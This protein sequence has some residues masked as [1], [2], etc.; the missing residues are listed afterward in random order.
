MQNSSRVALVYCEKYQLEEVR[1]AVKTGLN[2]LGGAEQFS[3]PQENIL[4]KVNML[5]G[6]N[7]DKCVGPHPMVF[8]AVL[9]QS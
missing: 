8:Q 2:L 5:V 1:Q 3:Q 7:P 9:E 6:D 4:V